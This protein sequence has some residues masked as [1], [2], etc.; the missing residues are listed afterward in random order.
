MGF[1]KFIPFILLAV[2]GFILLKKFRKPNDITAQQPSVNKMVACSTCTTH[3]PENEAI[4][5]NGKIYCS[6]DCL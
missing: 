2:I 1:I 4:I 5:Q 6:K 3:I